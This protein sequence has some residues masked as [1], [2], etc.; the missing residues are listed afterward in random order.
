VKDTW[1]GVPE[2]SREILL[3]AGVLGLVGL[4][5]LRGRGCA[6]V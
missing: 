5:R 2:P 3:F 1:E 4:S 6:P